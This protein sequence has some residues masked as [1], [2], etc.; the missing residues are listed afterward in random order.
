MPRAKLC[1]E[2]PGLDPTIVACPYEKC[3]ASK[4]FACGPDHL[5]GSHAARIAAAQKFDPKAGARAQHFVQLAEQ[6]V[7]PCRS[8]SFDPMSL[9]HLL[10]EVARTE[11]ADATMTTPSDSR[12]IEMLTDKYGEM[13]R[14]YFA[15]W[16]NPEKDLTEDE[17]ELATLLRTVA[18]EALAEVI[19]DL[20]KRRDGMS[21][22][23]YRFAVSM[24][25]YFERGDHRGTPVRP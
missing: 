12:A 8:C 25:G 21:D 14:T 19:A 11:T 22:T 1:R 13:A 2:P 16:D 23:E 18:E 24:A 15:R 17:A 4:G 20:R 5:S 10:Y 9:A 3:S 6:Y 7:E